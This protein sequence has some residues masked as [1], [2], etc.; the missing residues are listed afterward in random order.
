MTLTEGNR[1]YFNIKHKLPSL[2]YFLKT[3]TICIFKITK[4]INRYIFKTY[5]LIEDCARCEDCGRNVHDFSVPDDLWIEVYG[6]DGGV[7]CYDCFCNRLDEK[8]RFK[9]RM[10]LGYTVWE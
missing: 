4:V 2:D 6:N 9:H 1:I 5:T 7:L 8:L 3:V 10:L